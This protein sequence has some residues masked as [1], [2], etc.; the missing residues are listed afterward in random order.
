[1]LESDLET[2]ARFMYISQIQQATNRFV[3]LD[4][5]NEP[6]QLALFNSI[7]RD[8]FH[9]PSHEMYKITTDSG[10]MIASLVLTRK[11][12]SKDEPGVSTTGGQQK[13]A[14]IQIAGMNPE[15]R[16]VMRSAMMGVQNSMEGIDHLRKYLILQHYYSSPPLFIS[17]LM[18]IFGTC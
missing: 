14:P 7:M 3:F 12:P 17:G 18:L 5:P 15:V 10:E 16:P 13:P 1:M 8:M 4:W 9:D 2:A 11:T 6:A